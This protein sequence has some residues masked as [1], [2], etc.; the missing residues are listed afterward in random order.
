MT[1]ES[2]INQINNWALEINVPQN[3]L[4]NQKSMGF[5][6][7]EISKNDNNYLITYYERGSVV[8]QNLYTNP[9]TVLF[10]YFYSITSDMA[11]KYELNN[12]IDNQDTRKLKN[13]KHIELMTAVNPD[14]K[15]ETK[16]KIQ[17]I[18]NKNPY[19]DHFIFKNILTVLYHFA[20]QYKMNTWANILSKSMIEWN[21]KKTFAQFAKACNTADFLNDKKIQQITIEERLLNFYLY[22]L[23]KSAL[24]FCNYGV[25]EYPEYKKNLIW[26]RHCEY[27]NTS[28]TNSKYINQNIANTIIETVFK[29][30]L[31]YA[32]NLYLCD[33][34]HISKS[35]GTTHLKNFLEKML[36]LQGIDILKN[37]TDSLEKCINCKKKNRQ[38]SWIIMKTENEQY[39]LQANN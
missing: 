26:G 28:Q 33:I 25:V 5:D 14:W 21:E 30:N 23:K 2:I 19:N 11:Q 9:S 10:H 39:Y 18:L 35:V 37:E 38:A 32:E 15:Q 13:E 6:Y 3:L 29:E 17:K 27:C 8:F 7:T 24:S 22:W 36:P 31:A 1:I 20:L 12:R 16:D 34:D 4:P